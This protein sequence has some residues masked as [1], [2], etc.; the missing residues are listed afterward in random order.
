MTLPCH[1]SIMDGSWVCHRWSYL[2]GHAFIIECGGVGRIKHI[3]DCKSSPKACHLIRKVDLPINLE[4]KFKNIADHLLAESICPHYV[5]EV[6]ECGWN[7][8]SFHGSLWKFWLLFYALMRST[9]FIYY[10]RLFFKALYQNIQLKIKLL[11]FPVINHTSAPLKKLYQNSTTV[12]SGHS[13]ENWGHI[14]PTYTLMVIIFFSFS[15]LRL[16][17]HATIY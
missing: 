9:Q 14:E 4:L 17:Q 1:R 13:T 10:V 5:H 6:Y 3:K 15:P 7:F 2:V 12:N 11:A 16:L 8:D